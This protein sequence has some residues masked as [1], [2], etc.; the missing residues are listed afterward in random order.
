M[1][2]IKHTTQISGGKNRTDPILETMSKYTPDGCDD[3]YGLL[4][5]LKKISGPE[6]NLENG[7]GLA[8]YYDTDLNPLQIAI[9]RR[10]YKSV[11]MLIAD[12]KKKKKFYEKQIGIES[13]KTFSFGV[14]LTKYQNKLS[15]MMNKL[16]YALIEHDYTNGENLNS[17][18][19]VVT[20]IETKQCPRYSH[21]FES[22]LDGF[23]LLDIDE[24]FVEKLKN[25]FIESIQLCYNKGI[26]DKNP[27]TVTMY[28]IVRLTSMFIKF[29]KVLSDYYKK[30]NEH[31]LLSSINTDEHK[32]LFDAL[33]TTIFVYCKEFILALPHTKSIIDYVIK[34]K[35][36]L[37]MGNNGIINMNDKF[38]GTK[39]GSDPI[40]MENSFEG[41]TLL[42]ILVKNYK[43]SINTDILKDIRTD[44]RADIREYNL[45]IKDQRIH[46]DLFGYVNSIILDNTEPSKT[47]EYL[48]IRDVENKN[49]FDIAL[50]SAIKHTEA[51]GEHFDKVVSIPREIFDAYTE[52]IQNLL[53]KDIDIS[54]F[55]SI[56]KN[57]DYNELVSKN[58][59]LQT[60]YN[61]IKVKYS[62]KTPVVGAT[63]VEPVVVATSVEPVV[64]ASSVEPVVDAVPH[65]EATNEDN[66]SVAQLITKINDNVIDKLSPEC[67]DQLK[68]ALNKTAS[69][70]PPPIEGGNKSQKKRKIRKKKSHTRRKAKKTIKKDTHTKTQGSRRTHKKKLNHKKR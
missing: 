58:P 20:N 11:R 70:P 1:D 63:S 39:D 67:K 68:N 57:D 49:V 7:E 5:D 37:T 66:M 46:N 32:S 6:R 18:M 15:A 30:T 69:P 23:D 14:D 24:E 44:I 41:K 42:M 12:I 61:S 22:L 62:E 19:L 45:L 53:E 21:L 35:I 28:V 36:Y 55:G 16:K 17:L 26:V 51:N 27:T 64:D 3:M 54:N 56:V 9:E 40:E 60:I 47:K 65:V 31:V 33:L 25:R 29:D 43:S 50:L 2:T 48:D 34:N 38:L 8:L 4:I 13:K 59:R 10:C 52:T